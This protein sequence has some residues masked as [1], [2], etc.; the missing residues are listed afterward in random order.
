ML[1]KIEIRLSGSGGQGL[2]L[3]GIILADAAIEDGLNAT[4][5]QSYGPEARGGA[6]KAEVIISKEEINYPK[7]G[8]CD[9]LLC[10]TQKS[11]DKYIDSLNKSGI[12]VVDSEIE[13]D[14]NIKCK[15]YNLP[16]I[17]TAINEIGT[18]MVSNI[19]S[20]GVI[21]EISGILTEEAMKSSIIKRVP[22]GT[23]E[24]NMKAF[25][26]GKSLVKG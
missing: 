12:L 15:T 5:S 25:E 4:Q 24:L 23:G 16:I 9:L 6:S 14:E 3:G 18:P 10:L 7:V 8:S 26:R 20:L 11:Y 17:N 1:Q 22:A 21:S 2:I 13:V 19:V